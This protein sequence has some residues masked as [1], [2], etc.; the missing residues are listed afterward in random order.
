MRLLFND[1][2]PY[3]RKCAV[4][5]HEKG[6]A[7]Q[8]EIDRIMIYEQEIRDQN[9]LNKIPCLILEDGSGLF[10]S[11]VICDYLDRLGTGPAL[12]P[13]DGDHRTQVLRTHAIGQ[14]MTDAALNL[15]SQVMRDAKLDTPLPKDWYIERQWD[16][17]TASCKLLDRELESLQ[18]P[19]DLGQIS[20]GNG[21]GLSGSSVPGFR[22]AKSRTEPRGMVHRIRQSPLHAS[23]GSPGLKRKNAGSQRERAD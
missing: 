13:A 6:L 23:D 7:D 5:A 8:V 21:A 15:R 4:V 2:S 20:V 3:A 1:A 11:Y 19:L 14:G 9:P 10:D 17:I 16:A 12:I 22:V 18:G